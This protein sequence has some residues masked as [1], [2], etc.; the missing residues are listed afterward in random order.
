[1]IEL[2]KTGFAEEPDYMIFR[3]EQVSD[4]LGELEVYGTWSHRPTEFRYLVLESA[5]VK[6]RTEADLVALRAMCKVLGATR[7]TSVKVLNNLEVQK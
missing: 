4:A 5:D 2:V 1:M 7:E 6:A 3:V